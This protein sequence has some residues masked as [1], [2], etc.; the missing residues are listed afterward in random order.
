MK[1]LR[2]LNDLS[3]KDKQNV[4]IRIGT[5]N[6]RLKHEQKMAET[7]HVMLQEYRSDFA[8]KSSQGMTAAHYQNSIAFIHNLQEKSAMQAHKIKMMQHQIAVQWL[9][10]QKHHQKAESFQVLL[11]RKVHSAQEKEQKASRKEDDAIGTSIWLS[12]RRQENK[13]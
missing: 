11:T 12:Q 8:L 13:E 3:N 4:L 7:L 10:Y 1:T 6:Q 9:E 2:L 5:M